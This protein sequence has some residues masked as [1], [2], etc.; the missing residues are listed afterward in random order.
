M[1]AVACRSVTS[2]AM[3]PRTGDEIRESYLSWFE[4]RGH[5]RHDSDSLVPANDPTL[6]FTGAGMNQFKDYF[7]GKGTPPCARMTTAQKCLR[8]PDLENVGLTAGH[9]TFFEMLGNFSFGDYFKKECCEWVLGW[10]TE[11][12]GLPRDR[13]VVTIYQDDDEAYEIWRDHLDVAAERIYRFGD[14]E[15]FWPAEAPSKGPNGPCGP[16]S[17]IYYDYEPNEP[18]PSHEGLEELPRRFIEIGNCVFTQFDRQ[19]DGSLRPL[20]QKNIDVGLGLDRI[21]AVVQGKTSNFDTDIFAQ[22]I[23]WI[24]KRAGK[25]YGD[26]PRIDVHLRRIADHVRA[27]C[28]CIADGALPSNEGRG[29]VVRKIVRRACRDG[30]EV[31]LTEPFLSE[32]AGL[33]VARMGGQYPNLG[34][35]Q[36]QIEALL[37][38]EEQAFRQIYVHGEERFRKWFDA[39]GDPSAWASTE[40]EERGTLPVPP[41]SGAVAFE[42][43][44]T[45][46]FPVDITR[47]MLLDEGYALE[48]TGFHRAMEAQRT[49]AREGSALSGDVFADSIVTLLKERGVPTSSFTGHEAMVGKGAVLAICSGD[50]EVETASEGT[51]ELVLST[52]PAYAES[53]GQ[54][55]DIGHIGAANGRAR[56]V[57]T[58][59]RE[60]YRFHRIEIVEGALCKGDEVEVVIDAEAR[61]ATERNHT[62][63][64]LLHQ[65][66]KNVLGEQVGQAGSLVAPDRLRFDFTHGEKLTAEQIAAVEDEVTR[67]ILAATPVQP[68]DMSLDEAR[69]AG[70]VAMFGEKYGDVVRTLSVGDYS[71]ELCGGTHVANTGNI[72]LFRILT[73]ASI[74]AG[75]R[76]IEAATG[77]NALALVRAE[78]A[79]LDGV[80]QALRTQPA[81][82][83]QRVE[84]LQA[85][86]RQLRKE[87]AAT[88]SSSVGD[89]LNDLETKLEDSRGA[90]ILAA[91]I[92]D[93]NNKT[94]LDLL[95]RL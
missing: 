64:H 2:A 17:E 19:E 83:V 40:I 79:R 52:T 39:L 32:V 90:K 8:V 80:A 15:N 50:V 46:G 89:V 25:R 28:H 67:E 41:D 37:M 18:L 68:V 24:A 56:L 82:V 54:V 74:A 22:Y 11:A 36:R 88:R 55:G 47:A 7:R 65:A 4:E 34:D 27:A 13:L 57:D 30:Y 85:D 72:G 43:H 38:Q 9:H 53:G 12:L 91:S 71:R 63:T 69:A 16:C 77:L 94:L 1:A 48:E 5:R 31:G 93:A 23:E 33:V 3:R 51:V 6:L 35:A 29:Y 70:F 20:P 49:R 10:F 66:L 78:T 73:D 61:R 45:F 87:A 59:D 92:P 95:D 58:Q 21:T 44:D 76:R 60:G 42:L 86:V 14:K 75:V 26:N 81:D 84:A 62:A